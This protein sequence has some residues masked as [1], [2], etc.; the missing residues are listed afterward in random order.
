MDLIPS[1]SCKIKALK[2]LMWHLSREPI[3]GIDNLKRRRKKK[4]HTH[5]NDTWRTSLDKQENDEQ[6][7]GRTDFW[8]NTVSQSM[9]RVECIIAPMEC[10]QGYTYLQ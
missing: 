8:I 5:N 4:T 9:T 7:Y 2:A 6:A 3:L 1:A 10:Y